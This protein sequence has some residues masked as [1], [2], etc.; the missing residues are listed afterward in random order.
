MLFADFFRGQM[1]SI[2]LYSKLLEQVTCTFWSPMAMLWSSNV[3]MF[4][5][6]HICSQL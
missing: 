1:G 2:I 3:L 6:A 5:S 4:C